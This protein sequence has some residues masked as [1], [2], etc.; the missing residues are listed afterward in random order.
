MESR[1]EAEC[2][3]G[4]D[5]EGSRANNDSLYDNCSRAGA[6]H[7]GDMCADAAEMRGGRVS[8]DGQWNGA[9]QL[10]ENA[11]GAAATGAANHNRRAAYY[12]FRS[13]VY[14]GA[15]FTI[16]RIG[17]AGKSRHRRTRSDG[18]T[19]T[20]RC[21]IT[22]RTWRSARARSCVPHRSVSAIGCTL[23]S[24]D[25]VAA[26]ADPS[27]HS[28]DGRTAPVDTGL[29][30]PRHRN[31]VTRGWNHLTGDGDRNALGRAAANP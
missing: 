30:L 7:W 2:E 31:D 19:G 11:A 27:R 6:G 22:D 4:P 8:S 18:S 1:K 10:H 25:S 15:D 29:G 20:R 21:A 14:W 17:S 5:D 12:A 26:A 23:G 3:G 13:A 28:P 9:I 24:S 16:I